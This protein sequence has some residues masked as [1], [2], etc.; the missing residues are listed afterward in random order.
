[1]EEGEETDKDD[2]EGFFLR[3]PQALGEISRPIFL[4]S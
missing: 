4:V 1:M 2:H 3:P